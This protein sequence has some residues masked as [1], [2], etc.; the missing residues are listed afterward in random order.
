MGGIQSVSALPGDPTFSQFDNKYDVASYKRICAEFGVD[1]SSDFR[2]TRGANH[3]L[4][5]VYIWITNISPKN[6]GAKYPD[7]DKFSDE[8]GT[9]SKDTNLQLMR[10]RCG[11]TSPSV[12]VL[13]TES[14]VGYNNQL[15]QA[16]RGMKVGVNNDVNTSTKKAALKLMAGGPSK[17]NPPNSHPSNPMH[18]SASAKKNPAPAAS[19][20]ETPASNAQSAKATKVEVNDTHEI[21]KATVAFGAV[22]AAALLYTL[23]R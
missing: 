4:G 19:A 15:K 7:Y 12:Q 10:Q 17:V 20:A 18:K 11:S 9:A 2:F 13:N 16:V 6:S 22:G 14:V 8:G 23:M 21:N 5:D 1:P 3:G